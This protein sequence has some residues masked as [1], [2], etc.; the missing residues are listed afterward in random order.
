MPKPM[1]KV[2][3]IAEED[4]GAGAE[5]L[6]DVDVD[7]LA[8]AIVVVVGRRWWCLVPRFAT[9]TWSDL[10]LMACGRYARVSAGSPLAFAVTSNWSKRSNRRVVS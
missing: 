5:L 4:V 10:R 9:W 6:V 1:M 7:G 2:T 8:A 3:M